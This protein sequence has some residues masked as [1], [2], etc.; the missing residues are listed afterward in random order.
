MS[1]TSLSQGLSGRAGRSRPC[2][3]VALAFGYSCRKDNLIHS[4]PDAALDGF[5]GQRAPSSSYLQHMPMRTL[6]GSFLA[7]LVLG[8]GT[9]KALAQVN[10]EITW[11]GQREYHPGETPRYTD[12]VE[13]GE[14]VP[15][16]PLRGGDTAVIELTDD[17]P[18]STTFEWS[19]T[20]GTISPTMG[21]ARVNFT[22][23][24]P[25]PNAPASKFVT[26][27][28]NGGPV[29]TIEIKD[30]H[31]AGPRLV[32]VVV[33]DPHPSLG[34]PWIS[35]TGQATNLADPET[36]GVYFYNH[37]DAFYHANIWG[38]PA[39]M[40][41]PLNADGTFGASI[42]GGT[43]PADR[44]TMMLVSETV[45]PA[46]SQEPELWCR[47]LP[48]QVT[49]HILPYALD[50]YPRTFYTHYKLNGSHPDGLIQNL[51]GRNSLYTPMIRSFLDFESLFLYDQALAVIAFAHAGEQARAREILQYLEDIQMTSAD[52]A[53]CN[54]AWYYSYDVYGNPIGA[55]ENSPS[56][57]IAW[58][59]IAANTYH[60]AF[61]DDP[62]CVLPACDPQEFD[63]MA[64]RALDYL[65]D[66]VRPMAI[67]GSGPSAGTNPVRFSLN[68]LTQASTEHN[69]DAYSAFRGYLINNP[70]DP[71]YAA[72]ESARDDLEAFLHDMWHEPDATDPDPRFY[73][74]MANTNPTP[75]STGVNYGERYLDT[76]SWGVLALGTTGPGPTFYDYG[77]GVTDTNCNNFFEPAGYV[78]YRNTGVIGFFDYY[79]H[80]PGL[81]PQDPLYGPFVWSEGTLSQALAMDII[82]PSGGLTCQGNNSAAFVSAMASL[83][84]PNFTDSGVP[85]STYTEN[86]EFRPSS[87]IAGTAWQYFAAAGYNP[88]QP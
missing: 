38:Q 81:D 16:I 35:I 70:A 20:G 50:E 41:K 55:P 5:E 74:G 17:Y 21:S 54:G 14:V 62:T 48:D 40:P 66:K 51:L 32:N 44:I 30:V 23:A 82:D 69:L 85:Y 7:V 80:H 87:S 12:C 2:S 3:R 28:V 64:K 86:D 88:F 25:F 43:N 37:V 53:D 39:G 79:I 8:L 77:R 31:E 56:G 60:T 19:T 67:P 33:T 49:R 71:D 59:V 42:H 10:H 27:K 1:L 57:A 6:L 26:V 61:A 11:V 22:P 34:S 63:P 29:E 46:C 13:A 24:H 47:G 9:S 75:P 84:D 68:Q 36:Y 78:N 76:Q 15:C 65:K 73:A 58:V 72:Y 83:I 52:C 45:L 4:R 18:E